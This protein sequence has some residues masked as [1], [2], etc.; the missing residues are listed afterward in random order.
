MSANHNEG[1][2]VVARLGVHGFTHPIQSI[3]LSN[4]CHAPLRS[5]AALF[6]VLSTQG[7]WASDG[8]CPALAR[9]FS[10]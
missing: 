2:S 5:G 9:I 10:P 3:A 6:R 8:L 4:H 1:L 7:A